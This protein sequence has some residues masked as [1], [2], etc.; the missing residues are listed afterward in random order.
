MG[1]GATV[2]KGQ[3]CTI[4]LA[5]FPSVTTTQQHSVQTNSQNNNSNENCHAQLPAGAAPDRGVPIQILCV[6]A[7][8]GPIGTGHATITPSG[9]VNVTC[10]SKS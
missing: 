2:S 9:K 8:G 7:T 4:Q 5:P 3:E 10:H 1:E 6:T